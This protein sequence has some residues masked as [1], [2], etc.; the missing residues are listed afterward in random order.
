MSHSFLI[1]YKLLL[2]LTVKPISREYQYMHG[3]FTIYPLRVEWAHIKGEPHW[4]SGYER[5]V[6]V[7]VRS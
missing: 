6:T 7:V 1:T 5:G 2:G 4:I 3:K